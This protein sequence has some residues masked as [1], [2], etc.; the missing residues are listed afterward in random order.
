MSYIFI[1]TFTIE[2]VMTNNT[3]IFIAD[4]QLHIDCP[5]RHGTLLLLLWN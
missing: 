2:T 5:R 3:N 1:L 4:I